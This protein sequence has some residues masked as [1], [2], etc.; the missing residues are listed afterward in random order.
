M[1]EKKS[2]TGRIMRTIFNPRVWMNYEQVKDTTTYLKDGAFNL[3]TVPGKYRSNESFD[4]VMKRMGLTEEK[5]QSQKKALFRLSIVMLLMSF[6]VLGYAI[7]HFYS[8]NYHT[9]GASTVIFFVV[10]ALA[11]RYHFWYFQLK[12]RRLGCSMKEWFHRGLLGAKK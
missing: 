3:F 5:V 11:F 6:L 9:A 1:A 12:E 10:L 8:G 2:Q 4:D 7:S